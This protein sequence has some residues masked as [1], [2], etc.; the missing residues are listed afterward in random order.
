MKRQQTLVFVIM[1]LVRCF[2]RFNLFGDRLFGRLNWQVHESGDA[3]TKLGDKTAA[4][5]ADEQMPTVLHALNERQF[6][7][8]VAASVFSDLFATKHQATSPL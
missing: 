5:M 7:I 4:V 1:R 2:H 8:D 6:V 3:Q